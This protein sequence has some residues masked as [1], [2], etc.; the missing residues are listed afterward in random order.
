[1]LIRDSLAEFGEP[2]VR[3]RNADDG[4]WSP[5]AIATN[6]SREGKFLDV[7]F[8]GNR[9]AVENNTFFSQ[10]VKVIPERKERK[11]T[12]RRVDA[13]S[14][15]EGGGAARPAPAALPVT[16]GRNGQ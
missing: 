16:S 12:H 2:A 7:W 11:W 14:V 5:N 9:Q 8:D 1:M 6:Q 15:W 3:A 13:G 4:E 10:L